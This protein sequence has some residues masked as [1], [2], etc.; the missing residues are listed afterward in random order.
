MVG[1]RE[2]ESVA[3]RLSYCKMERRVAEGRQE[4]KEEAGD[5]VPF[6]PPPSLLR[7]EDASERN[8]FCDLH[9]VTG[10]AVPSI[11]SGHC[12][13]VTVRLIDISTIQVFVK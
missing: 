7:T 8:V 11:K 2:E 10:M 3:S 9:V 6:F 5:D 12:H 4:E 1:G 13:L